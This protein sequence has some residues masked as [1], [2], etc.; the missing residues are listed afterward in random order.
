M[1]V[2]LGNFDE[3]LPDPASEERRGRTFD[4]GHAVGELQGES[5]VQPGVHAVDA[6][7]HLHCLQTGSAQRG[8]QPLQLH[9]ACVFVR[10]CV[11][12]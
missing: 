1:C 8:V 7:A 10:V 4:G 9:G 12:V 3:A 11:G 5:V 6:T 2:W